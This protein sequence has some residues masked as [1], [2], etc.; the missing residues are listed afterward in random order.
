MKIRTGFVSNSSTSSFLIAYNPD[1][2]DVCPHCGCSDADPVKMAENSSRSFVQWTMKPDEISDWSQ[3][4][5]ETEARIQKQL[6]HA[7]ELVVAGVTHMEAGRYSN[8]RAEHAVED[9]SEELEN[10]RKHTALVKDKVAM[11]KTIASLEI[12]QHDDYVMETF[13]KLL[14]SGQVELLV[15]GSY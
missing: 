11:G 15:E 8:Y 2:F 10:H 5:R 3:D 4:Q 6:E 13:R 9:F 1:D 12:E 14:D 7:Q